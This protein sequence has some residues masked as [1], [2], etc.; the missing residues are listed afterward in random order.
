MD[1]KV[2]EIAEAVTEATVKNGVDKIRAKVRK[3]DPLFDGA[4]EECDAQI[5]DLRLDTG[6]TT[7]L[8]CQERLEKLQAQYKR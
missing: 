5:P 4:C 3:R 8:E 2:L 6:A 1:E 7:C